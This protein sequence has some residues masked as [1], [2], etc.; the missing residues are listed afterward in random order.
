MRKIEVLPYTSEWK[1]MFEEEKERLKSIFDSESTAIHHIGSTAIRGLQAKPIIDMLIVVKDMV[2]IDRFDPDMIAIG[3][4]PK[5]ENGI[6]GRRYFQKGGNIRTHHA[7]FFPVSHP[8]IERHLAFRDYLREHLNVAE[9]Y[10]N[11]KE[12]LSWQFPF[13][14]VS[15]IKGKQPLMMEI[16][17]MAIA[18]YRQQ[19]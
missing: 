11:Y 12:K 8:A 13:D 3:Y 18:W 10:G 19:K 17:Q 2:H 6:I 5:G 16:E 1:I 14:K 4:V 7:H 15:Y 9:K